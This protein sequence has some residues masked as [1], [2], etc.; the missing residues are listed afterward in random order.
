MH[1]RSRSREARESSNEYINNGHGHRMS[2]GEVMSPNIEEYENLSSYALP[3][4]LTLQ[5]ELEIMS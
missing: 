2:F 5:E 4:K 1:E 3:K